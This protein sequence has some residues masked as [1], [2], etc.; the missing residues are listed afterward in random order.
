MFC[1]TTTMGH[2]GSIHLF[3]DSMWRWQC[4]D[5]TNRKEKIILSDVCKPNRIYAKISI[6]RHLNIPIN[7]IKIKSPP[8]VMMKEPYAAGT[9]KKRPAGQI[10]TPPSKKRSPGTPSPTTRPGRK[11]KLEFSP[12]CRATCLACGARIDKGDLRVSVDYL[13]GT[14]HGKLHQSR[15]Y[16][17]DCCPMSEKKRLLPGTDD[18]NKCWEDRI[19][20]MERKK[21]ERQKTIQSDRSELRDRLL[22]LR[23][24][25][26][27][28]QGRD[29]ERPALIITH[30]MVDNIVYN[31]P[32]T[33]EDLLQVKGIGPCMLEQYGK[34][35]LSEVRSFVAEQED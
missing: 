28:R 20:I 19:E 35:L 30:M 10:R 8:K 12:N 7:T 24:K 33:E 21:Q 22:K 3:K 25:L 34:Q 32:T 5:P 18:V 31:L 23:V 1:F 29:K 2:E 4:R 11:H 26:H 13:W 17:T 16:H 6:A 9:D 14:G 27:E 15:Y